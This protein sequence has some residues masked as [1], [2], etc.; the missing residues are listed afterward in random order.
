MGADNRATHASR[1]TDW[2]WTHPQLRLPPVW[3]YLDRLDRVAD[4]LSTSKAP[5]G[6]VPPL[7]IDI[8]FEL[9]ASRSR[10]M[11]ATV[12]PRRKAA[13]FLCARATRE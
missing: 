10:S 3:L 12:M 5:V 7:K 13:T 11:S 1:D 4:T 8:T 2:Y 9:R 6:E